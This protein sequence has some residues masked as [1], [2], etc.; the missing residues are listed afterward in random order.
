MLEVSVYKIFLRRGVGLVKLL[1]I[2]W[3]RRPPPYI[4]TLSKE[5]NR[6]DNLYLHL[7]T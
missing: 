7:E 2:E 5:T 3:C 4:K 1:R 6:S